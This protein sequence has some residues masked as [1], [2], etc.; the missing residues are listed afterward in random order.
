MKIIPTIA[1]LIAFLILGFTGYKAWDYFNMD[2]IAEKYLSSD[3][4]MDQNNDQSNKDENIEDDHQDTD[5][6]SHNHSSQDNE[7][8][9]PTAINTANLIP[10]EKG[11][12]YILPILENLGRRAVGNPDAP[13][14]LQEFF[15][16]TCN[17]CATFHSE[18]YPLIK[19]KYIDTGKIYFI[20]EEF[21]L[22]GPALFGSMIARCMPKERYVGFIDLLLKNQEKWAFGG[23]FKTAL[24]QNAALAGMGSD[25]FET[26]FANE[27]LKE[28]MATN[29]KNASENWK[30]SSTPSFVFNNGERILRGSNSIEQFDKVYEHL[31]KLNAEE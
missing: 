28:E 10:G 21:P 27:T 7:A 15:S 30:I 16:L 26:C 23:D 25:D 17:H 1:L 9:A 22:N 5:H 24:K 4:S 2:E 14:Q 6:S 12:D 13:V 18:I 31:T 11:K 3:N 29:I 20:Y 19:E 8:S